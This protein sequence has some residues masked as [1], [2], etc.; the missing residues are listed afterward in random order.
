MWLVRAKVLLAAGLF[1]PA[2]FAAGLFSAP[3]IVRAEAAP[4]P[5]VEPA[6]PV[7]GPARACVDD[8]AMRANANLVRQLHEA[9]ARLREL[10]GAK[11]EL[12]A[13]EKA[14]ASRVAS[15][16]SVPQSEWTRMARAKMIHV[17]TPCLSWDARG[18][19][20]SRTPTGT[21]I[22]MGGGPSGAPQRA[23]LAGL[24]AAELSTLEDAYKRAHARTWEKV[25]RACADALGDDASERADGWKVARCAGVKIRPSSDDAKR[26]IQAV[27]ELRAAGRGSAEA[28]TD[29]E[30]ILAAV[31]ESGDVLMDELTKAMGRDRASRASEYGLLCVDETTYWAEA[32]KPSA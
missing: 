15:P 20:V 28:R 24:D 22:S 27:A 19:S 1:A 7:E 32:P 6:P 17:R 4:P 8:D 23:E 3:A 9:S 12:E 5:P 30:R 11:A 10:E 14:R 2:V 13:S 25:K 29:E 16:F 26:A 21:R 31:A 18:R